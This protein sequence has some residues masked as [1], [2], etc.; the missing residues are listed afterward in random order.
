[1]FMLDCMPYSRG[2]RPMSLEAPVSLNATQIA[3]ML[4]FGCA[5]LM[6]MQAAWRGGTAWHGIG[7]RLALIHAVLVLEIALG[8]RHGLQRVA[9]EWLRIQ[10][11]YAGRADIQIALLVLLAALV[12]LALIWVL[13]R[14][15]QAGTSERL[16]VVGTLISVALV[17]AETV[18]LHALDAWLYAPVGPLLRIGWVWLAAGMWTVFGA[19]LAWRQGQRTAAEAAAAP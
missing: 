17:A 6:C 4:S 10:Q 13:G 19:G 3:G 7:R 5:A 11:A 2:T 9:G 1:L 14:L 16:A 15:H 18:S 8:L 12:L